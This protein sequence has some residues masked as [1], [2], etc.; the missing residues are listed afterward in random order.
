MPQKYAKLSSMNSDRKQVTCICDTVHHVRL[1]TGWTVRGSNPVGA[2]F[3]APVQ[4]GP[5][6]LL[7]NKYRIF[8]GVKSGRGVR[9]TPHP[10]LVPW[11]R[12]CRATALLPLWAVR[13]VHSLSACTRVHFNFFLPSR[14]ARNL[15]SSRIAFICFF[16]QRERGFV[17]RL[18]KYKSCLCPKD[19]P[20]WV[21]TATF[22]LK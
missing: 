19:P 9:L 4:T 16:R 14:P 11:S 6:S 15:S 2:R 5:P 10:L 13:T 7:C 21:P 20:L 12:K 1:A 3:S 8:P 18:S 22:H 17:W